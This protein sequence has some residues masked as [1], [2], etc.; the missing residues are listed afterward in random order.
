MS[1]GS[2]DSACERGRVFGISASPQ[3]AA[4][5]APASR[6]VRRG[7][8]LLLPRWPAE[9]TTIGVTASVT[10]PTSGALAMLELPHPVT[11][12]LPVAARNHI[13]IVEDDSHVASVIR[14]G[15]ELE[16][17]ANW[18]VQSAD[19]GRRALEIAGATPPDVVLLDVRLPGLGG[20]EVYRRLRSN[21]CTRGARI[22]F[23]SAGT[24]F[25]LH[26]LGIEDG[27]LLRKPFDLRQ[28]VGLVRALLQG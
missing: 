22:L 5:A 10:P 23:L 9:A 6:R 14:A 11:A 4:C 20:A 7:A 12:P 24:A 28:L 3:S 13:L 21:Q 18:L 27:V 26:Q 8:P 15:L 25:D 1:I 19:E 16:G 2:T 17:E